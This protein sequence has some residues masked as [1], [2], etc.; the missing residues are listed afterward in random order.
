[1]FVFARYFSAGELSKVETAIAIILSVV[2]A[3]VSY[4]FIESPFRGGDSPIT[5]R[6][7][8]SL[9]LAASLLSAAVGFIIYSHQ[10]VPHRY[11]DSTRQ[12][13]VRNTERKG[14]YQD[15]CGNWRK[16]FRSMADIQF[17][18]LGS[19]SS[20]KSMFWGDSHVQQL[21]PLIKGIYDDSGFRDHGVLFAV[22]TGCPPTEHLNRSGFHCDSFARLAMARAE[23]EDVD[24]VFMGFTT[25][26]SIETE[27]PCPS[28]EGRCV[29][30]ISRE[31]MIQ[32][33]FQ[34]L[35]QHIRR[36][37][38][39]GKRVIV[40]LPFPFFDKSIPDLEVRNAVFGRFGLAGVVTELTLPTVRDQVASVAESSGA[41]IFDPRKSLCP[42]QN[43]ITE[44]GGV[45]IYK[46]NSHIAA[47]Q[48]GIL[49]GNMEQVLR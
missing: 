30:N 40:S 15:V 48:I 6:Q 8:F 49:E 36:L 13:V 21:Y 26:W 5:R 27:W 45:S 11:N 23:E 14:D 28:V 10:G 25:A 9:G 46:D 3:F 16:E 38:I 1:M 37:K 12:L 34:E 24:T 42:D 31:E 17:C 29:G 33:F 41:D 7:I 44:L 19:P 35:S 43:C 2:M 47:S 18:N 39:R 32:R 4:E 20:K 22:S